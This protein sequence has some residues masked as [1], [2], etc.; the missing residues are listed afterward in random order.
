MLIIIRG[1]STRN[2]GVHGSLTD[3]INRKH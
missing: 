2:S 3:Q 1:I